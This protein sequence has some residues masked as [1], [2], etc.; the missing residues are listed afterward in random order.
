M[1]CFRKVEDG[2]LWA[3][4]LYSGQP[5]ETIYGTL[6]WLSLENLVA[7]LSPY[8]PNDIIALCNG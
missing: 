3:R 8:V 4:V 7:I 5:I 1:I 6:D 2:S